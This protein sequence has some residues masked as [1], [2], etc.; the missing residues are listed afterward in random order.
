MNKIGATVE[1]DVRNINTFQKNIPTIRKSVRNSLKQ[2]NLPTGGINFKIEEN[3]LVE[4][5]CNSGLSNFKI[6]RLQDLRRIHPK[7]MSFNEHTIKIYRRLYQPWETTNFVYKKPHSFYEN[8]AYTVL[9]KLIQVVEEWE[10]SYTTI[11]FISPFDGLKLL[12]QWCYWEDYCYFEED[13]HDY[14]YDNGK[15]VSEEY[16]EREQ[17]HLIWASLVKW[18]E[19]FNRGIILNT[20]YMWTLLTN[21]EYIAITRHNVL[22]PIPPQLTDTDRET[23]IMYEKE[24]FKQSVG[25]ADWEED[26]PLLSDEEDEEFIKTPIKHTRRTIVPPAPKKNPWKRVT[27]RTDTLSPIHFPS[28]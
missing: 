13:Y 1:I 14:F 15:V 18:E 7:T 4:I 9:E 22:P 12:E 3:G 23:R 16:W 8:Q 6:Q 28:L 21:E 26:V 20:N 2:K 10:K 5:E 24:E 25:W 19:F 27:K 11:D 17:E